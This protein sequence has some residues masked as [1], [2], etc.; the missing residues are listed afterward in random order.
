MDHTNPLMRWLWPLLASFAGSVTAMSFRS[1]KQM[2]AGEIAVALF[3]G[4]SFSIFVTPL[5][6]HMVYG[7]VPSINLQ[8]LGAMFYITATSWN[9][10][11]PWLVRRI[12]SVAGNG[13]GDGGGNSSGNSSSG[14]GNEGDRP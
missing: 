13:N 6:I 8:L 9:I 3:V 2:T 14:C 1:F 10:L 4:A 12:V 11:L 5:V 7:P